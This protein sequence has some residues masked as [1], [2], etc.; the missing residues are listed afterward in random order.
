MADQACLA[1]AES[2]A[3]SCYA[4]PHRHYH[5]ER[6]LDDCL[7]ILRTLTD[8]DERE[9]QILRW[10]ILWHDAIYDPRRSDNEK[11]S[12]ELAFQDLTRCGVGEAEAQHVRR[13]IL[14][15]EDHRVGD[16]DHLSAL[17]VS[18]DLSILGADPERYR[19][20][21]E[22]VRREYVHVSDDAWRA[23][24]SAILEKLLAAN[25]LYPDVRFRA[26]LETRARRNLT[27]ELIRLSAS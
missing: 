23:G 10:A 5:D 16:G 20:Y 4:E 24:R 9:E 6:H 12:G 17:L 3:R 18:I 22:G 2:R 8:I 27:D 15:T 11:R 1:E 21:A 19:D 7:A 26:A 13:L 25:P 14:L